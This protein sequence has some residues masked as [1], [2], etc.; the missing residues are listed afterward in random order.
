MGLTMDKPI[1]LLDEPQV[2][3]AAFFPLI[4]GSMHG[5]IRMACIAS[6]VETGVFEELEEPCPVSVLASRI[7]GTEEIVSELCR[8]LGS[9]GLLIQ[10]GTVYRNS[11]LASTYLVRS[12]QFSQVRYIEKT[13]RQ[14]VDLFVR[15]PVIMR[16]GPVSYEKEHFFRDLSLPA[17]AENALTGRLQRTIRP[18]TD[19]PGFSSFRRM[20]DLGG[21]HGLYAI[22]L[23][24]ANPLLEAV[25]FDLPFVTALADDY[26]RKYGATRVKTAGG[27]FFTDEIGTGYDLVFSSSNPSGKSIEMLSKI[28]SALNPGGVFVNVQSGDSEPK[29][30]YTMLEMKLWTLGNNRRDEGHRTK[31][32]PFLTPEYREALET[33][34]LTIIFSGDITDDYHKG[35]VV[36]MIIAEKKT[37]SG[38]GK[39]GNN[40]GP[41]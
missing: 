29:D 10:S 14:S 13:W 27:N 39:K 20:I 36:Q 32:Q 26:I 12:S 2:P 15:L 17:M 8:V 30:V 38:S 40:G 33:C 6:A 31:E 9:L 3:P 35:S 23:A 11:A 7:N 19:L 16:C 4:D 1:N 24:Q 34:G 5:L 41:A 18:I 28:S 21:G 25:V 22:A 37:G